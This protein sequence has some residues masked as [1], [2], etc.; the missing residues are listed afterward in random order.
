MKNE[1]ATVTLAD[2]VEDKIIRYIKENHLSPGDSLPNEME[3]VKMMGISRNV[4]REAMSRLRM[5]GLIQTRPKRGIIV[6]E[7]PLLNGLKKVLDPNLLS[8]QTIK[9]MM[10]MRIAMEIGITDF[11]FTNIS[12]EDITELEQIVSRQQAIG[13][14]NLSIED[15]MLF[16]T[17]IYEIAG[18]KFILQFNEIMHPVFVFA[19]ENYENYFQPINVKLKDQDRIVRHAD[20]LQLIKDGKK[21]GYQNAM[22]A[23]LQPYWEF[24][25]NQDK[26]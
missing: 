19:K 7:P 2:Q 24:L 13:I 11:I 15:E 25:Y 23:H 6:T 16:H 3:F 5:L 17:K 1:F 21:D 14:N 26:L 22:K 20:L 9:E 8:I 18:N 10:G 12:E 4:V